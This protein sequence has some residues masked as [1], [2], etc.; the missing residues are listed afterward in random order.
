MPP[1]LWGWEEGVWGSGLGQA[2]WESTSPGQET[3]HPPGLGAQRGSLG[4]QSQS[5]AL[6]LKKR[7]LPGFTLK[8]A[9]HLVQI[10]SVLL[11]GGFFL[12][13]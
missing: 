2:L 3:A 6:A 8:N 12:P 5:Q 11:K 4:E 10:C 9:L 1:L 7:Q 13:L